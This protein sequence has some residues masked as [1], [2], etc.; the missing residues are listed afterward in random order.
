M[1]KLLATLVAALAVMVCAGPAF[2][3]DNYAAVYNADGS[4]CATA[5]LNPCQLFVEQGGVVYGPAAIRIAS[6]HSQWCVNKWY[7]WG[8]VYACPIDV[9]ENVKL[10]TPNPPGYH[11]ADVW[12][13]QHCPVGGGYHYSE[14]HTMNGVPGGSMTKDWSSLHLSS[15]CQTGSMPV[16]G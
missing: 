2:A 10:T 8:W 13:R 3:L 4:I 11:N 1:N 5:A 9:Y 12:A 7:S 16:F 14:G 6:W 15:N